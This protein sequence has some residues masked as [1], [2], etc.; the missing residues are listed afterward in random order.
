MGSDRFDF[1]PNLF[2]GISF[3]SKSI[4][5]SLEKLLVVNSVYSVP[6]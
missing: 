6:T 3:R 2:R 1:P 4:K 5:N